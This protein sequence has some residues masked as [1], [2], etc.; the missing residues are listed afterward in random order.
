LAIIYVDARKS[1]VRAYSLYQDFTSRRVR[2]PHGLSA[3]DA[4]SL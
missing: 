2:L 3:F 4:F 1:D